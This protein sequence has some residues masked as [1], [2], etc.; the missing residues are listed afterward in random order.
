V[1]F[2]YPR[3]IQV[4]RP[5]AQAGVGFQTTYSGLAR[6]QET[7]VASGVKASIQARREG[8]HGAVGLPADATKPTWYV[9]I[10]KR[11][12]ANGAVRDR[13]IIEDDLGLRYQVIAP[14]W[15]SLGYRLSTELLEA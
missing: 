14:Y 5:A 10:P 12:L 13:D 8:Q 1:S 7:V 2:L 15:D 4:R 11:A 3:T 9:F 6:D